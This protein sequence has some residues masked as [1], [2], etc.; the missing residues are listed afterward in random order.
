MKLKK[1]NGSVWSVIDCVDEVAAIRSLLSVDVRYVSP[2]GYTFAHFAVWRGW[3]KFLAAALDAGAD[4]KSVSDAGDRPDDMAVRVGHLECVRT[5]LNAGASRKRMIRVAES[6]NP[7]TTHQTTM[8]RV[9][10]VL[11]FLKGNDQ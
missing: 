3:P 7:S 5:L 4:F 9:N 6:L 8:D 10:K 11:D 2:E 1:R